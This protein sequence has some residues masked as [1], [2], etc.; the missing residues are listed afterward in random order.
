MERPDNPNAAARAFVL[1][2]LQLLHYSG[3]L[4]TLP[5]R[6]SGLCEGVTRPARVMIT[7]GARLRC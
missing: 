2:G 1:I 3:R 6:R 7:P 5:D 4:T